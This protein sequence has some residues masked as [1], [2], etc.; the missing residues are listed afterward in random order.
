MSDE[1]IQG[2]LDFWFGDREASD[3]AI[4]ERQAPLWWHARPEDDQTIGN[5]FG[6]LAR[7]AVEG[8][9]DEWAETAHGRLALILLLD[10]FPRAIYRG[11]A[12]AYTQDHSA[13]AHSLQAQGQGQDHEL[14]PVER[15]FI[16]TPMLH[17]ESLMV[18][19]ECVLRFQAL[20]D[21]VASADRPVFERLLDTARHRREVILRFDRFPHRNAL[22]GRVSTPA[23]S[24]FLASEDSTLV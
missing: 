17:A 5:N 20:L 14:R 2:I 9:L 24:D 11:E 23:E 7:H 22:V 4:A 8:H 6:D 10:Q 15:V 13:L 18:Q 19:D 3:S 12:E 16:Y 1:H 21:Q